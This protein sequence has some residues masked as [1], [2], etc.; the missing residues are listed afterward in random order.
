MDYYSNIFSFQDQN[1][2]DVWANT[3]ITFYTSCSNRI[4]I[5]SNAPCRTSSLQS[6]TIDPIPTTSLSSAQSATQTTLLFSSTP[7]PS[8]TPSSGTPSLSSTLDTSTVISTAE[9]PSSTSITQHDSS[10]NIPSS[11]T[12]AIHDHI[13]PS[14]TD[15]QLSTTAENPTSTKFT[16]IT[17]DFS[18]FPS[19]SVSTDYSSSSDQQQQLTISKIYHLTSQFLPTVTMDTISSSE[20]RLFPNSSESAV[21][22]STTEKFAPSH[23]S[24]SQTSVTTSTHASLPFE[25]PTPTDS[26]MCV[27]ELGIW[28]EMLACKK[29]E[30]L[31][32]P[33]N[34]KLANG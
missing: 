25:A 30:I 22:A 24:S 14:S 26:M 1:H 8:P 5:P 2:V 32:C 34:S 31:S 21:V 15:Q 9:L 6:S 33:N 18:V 12:A 16:S 29:S 7:S 11:S 3:R 10:S 19:P 20:S 23:I 17:A 13:T 28:N 27:E 4:D